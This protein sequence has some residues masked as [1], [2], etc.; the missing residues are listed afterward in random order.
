MTLSQHLSIAIAAALILTALQMLGIASLPGA[1]S[2]L[3]ANPVVT[4]SVA[5]AMASVTTMLVTV[6]TLQR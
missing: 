5:A 1:G 3:A 6:L 4:L 2:A